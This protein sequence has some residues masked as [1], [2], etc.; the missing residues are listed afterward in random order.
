MCLCREVNDGSGACRGRCA[1]AGLSGRSTV[2]RARRRIKARGCGP[3]T[4]H[5]SRR[6]VSAMMIDQSQTRLSADHMPDA[7]EDERWLWRTIVSSTC[8]RPRRAS[9][10]VPVRRSPEQTNWLLRNEPNPFRPPRPANRSAIAIWSARSTLTQKCR[11]WLMAAHVDEF[12][13][14]LTTITSGS[15]DKEWA[16]VVSASLTVSPRC[17]VSSR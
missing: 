13:L 1:R 14:M 2:Q 17:F 15:T 12:R 7:A 11:C 4:A 10:Q 8:N 9:L 5:R 3:L 6:S 16:V